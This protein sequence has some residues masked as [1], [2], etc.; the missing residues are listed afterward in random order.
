MS[1][2]KTQ[3]LHILFRKTYKHQNW[4]IS[5]LGLGAPTYQVCGYLMSRDK[6][7]TLYFYFSYVAMRG[8]MTNGLRLPNFEGSWY[9]LN[10]SARLCDF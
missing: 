3:T 6:I 10:G 9:W 8:Y 1:R 5:D 2:D 7:K 4:Q